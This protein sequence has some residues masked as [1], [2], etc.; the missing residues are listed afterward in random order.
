MNIREEM[1]AD[2][3]DLIRN[4]NLY[5]GM[6]KTCDEAFDFFESKLNGDDSCKATAYLCEVDRRAFFTGARAILD[7]ITGKDV[8]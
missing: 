7:A 4:N 5:A 3:Y 2:L 6:S 1:I 8:R